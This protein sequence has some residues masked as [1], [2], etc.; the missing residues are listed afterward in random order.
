[1][2][3]EVLVRADA[4]RVRYGRRWALDGLSSRSRPARSSDCSGRTAPA[5]RR[6]SPSWRR[7]CRRT[8]ARRGR[9]P[10]RSREPRARAPRAR[11][12][13]PVAGT[14]PHPHGAR[15]HPLLRPPARH[16]RPDAARGDA[17][18]AGAGGPGGSRRRSGVDVLG[19]HAAPTE[20]RLRPAARA[21][22]RPARRAHG[23][24]RS[25]VPRAH[26]RAPCA[27]R[28][29]AA[30]PCS[31]APTTW[32]RPSACA[33]GSV[34][35]DHGRVVASGTPAELVHGTGRALR[36]EVITLSPLPDDWLAGIAGVRAPRRLPR[37][38][39]RRRARQ[40]CAG[41]G[42]RLRH[43]AAGSRSRRRAR[44]RG[45]RLPPP[46]AGPAGRLSGA[47]RSRAARLRHDSSFRTE[48]RRRAH[49]ADHHPQ[50]PPPPV[51]RPRRADLPHHRP[52]RGHQRCRLLARQPLRRR[53]HRA[54]GIRLPFRRR[55]RQRAGAADP[56]ARWRRTGGA[57]A[58]GRQ[59]GR[60]RAAGPRQAG[61][62]GA[63]RPAGTQ[64][65]LAQGRAGQAHPLHRRGE[66]PGASQLLRPPARAARRRS[67]RAGRAGG[68]GERAS[69]RDDC[70]ASWNGCEAPSPMSAAAS[71]RRGA[72]RW[73]RGSAV[74]EFA[75]L[76]RG[77]RRRAAQRLQREM[78]EA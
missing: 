9:G 50:G 68:G 78:D 74:A 45:A 6:R 70:S 54:D 2:A 19:W 49:A 3:R 75:R 28:R 65:A 62:H 10:L 4:V 37:G 42:R 41:R 17:V 63:G 31:T 57:A 24:R 23:G 21:A 58:S 25:T 71:R 1:M 48:H 52:D 34:L 27:A 26:L 47:H 56:R 51:A 43:R 13:P 55:G 61:R 38:L 20:P 67:S 30:R 69:R 7:C 15:E 35:V 14:L 72:R 76:S 64:E 18:G 53:P 40:R 39:R 60:G 11:H 77:R 44:R 73:R 22:R 32:R 29:R 16:A 5:K 46:P 36:L 12:G 33:T 8:A 66:V 59:P